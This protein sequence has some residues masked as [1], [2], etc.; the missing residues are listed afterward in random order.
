MTLLAS[1][2]ATYGLRIVLITLVP[3]HRL[4]AVLRRGLPHLA[5]AALAGLVATA[6]AGHAGPGALVAPGPTHL[7]LAVAGLVAWR[8]RNPALPVL[9]AVVVAVA[10]EVLS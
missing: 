10:W 5:P 7:A 9:A 1:A 6:L 4:P 2:V 3:A 8:F